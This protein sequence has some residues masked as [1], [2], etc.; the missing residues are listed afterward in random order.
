MANVFNKYKER[1]EMRIAQ[2]LNER[3]ELIERAYNIFDDNDDGFLQP[4]ELKKLFEFVYDLNLEQKEGRRD[5]RKIL[6]E[7]EITD[8]DTCD[9]E[10]VCDFLHTRGAFVIAKGSGEKGE[11]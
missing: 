2:H 9:R 6:T 3:Q 8:T 1:L 7:M 5:Y 4:D 11:L 10:L